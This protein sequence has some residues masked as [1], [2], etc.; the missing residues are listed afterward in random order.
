MVTREFL[1]RWGEYRRLIISRIR[2]VMANELRARNDVHRL[3]RLDDRLLGDIGVSR[4]DIDAR[5]LAV[6]SADPIPRSEALGW[7][8]RPVSRLVERTPPSNRFRRRQVD[9]RPVYEPFGVTS[10]AH[11]PA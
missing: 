3:Q 6:R 11:P 9:R 4:A 8:T 10:S 7:V 5:R 2:R 1:R